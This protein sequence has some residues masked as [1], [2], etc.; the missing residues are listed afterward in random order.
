M[1]STH[2]TYT[3]IFFSNPTVSLLTFPFLLCFPRGIPAYWEVNPNSLYL[4]LGFGDLRNQAPF[5]QEVPCHKMSQHFITQ[6]VVR[7]S[8]FNTMK[9]LQEEICKLTLKET[10]F[11]FS[12]NTTT[13]SKLKDFDIQ[14]MSNKIQSLA[15]ARLCAVFAVTWRSY[16]V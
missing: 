6:L 4:E 14:S 10:G 15:P 8:S 3:W 12:A 5:P 16:F 11:H 1:A 13:E 7:W 9:H 2:L